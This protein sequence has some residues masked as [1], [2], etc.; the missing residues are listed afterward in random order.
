MERRIEIED[1]EGEVDAQPVG[2]DQADVLGEVDLGDLGDLEGERHADDEHG[3]PGQRI[4]R[5]AGDGAVDEQAQDLGLGERQPGRG[6]QQQREQRDLGPL[7]PEV[8]REQAP[9]AERRGAS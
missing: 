9:V 3:D 6:E 5:L 2:G 8:R 4:Q 7:G 1:V